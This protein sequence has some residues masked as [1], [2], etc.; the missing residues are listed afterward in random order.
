M[1][2]QP[3]PITPEDLLA[4]KEVGDVQ[5]SPDGALIAFVVADSFKT[6]TSA[7]RSQIWVVPAAGGAARP[8]TTGPRADTAPRWSPDGRTL[9]FL[10]DREDD[11]TP[12]IYLLDRDGGEARRLTNQPCAVVEIAWSPDGTR[13]AFNRGHHIYVMNADGTNAVPVTQGVGSNYY[14]DWR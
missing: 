9:A 13:I 14:P 6:D 4:F 8:W 10:S 7:P 5:I 3:R 11:G 12:Q 1:T 2:A